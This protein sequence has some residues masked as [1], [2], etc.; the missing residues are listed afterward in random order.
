VAREPLDAVEGEVER[1]VEL[2]E[3]EALES[4]QHHMPAPESATTGVYANGREP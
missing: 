4:R 3:Q 1:E 2:A